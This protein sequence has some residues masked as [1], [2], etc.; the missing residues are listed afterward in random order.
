MTL[1]SDKREDRLR[2]LAEIDVAR[3]RDILGA[4]VQ[5]C[6]SGGRERL[7]IERLAARRDCLER[8]S[9]RGFG[10]FGPAGFCSPG[11]CSPGLGFRESASL[12]FS[13]LGLSAVKGMPGPAAGLSSTL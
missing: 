6:H 4:D 12:C 11:F 3:R 8:E 5:K 13:S 9:C 10:G 2:R 1:P 7:G